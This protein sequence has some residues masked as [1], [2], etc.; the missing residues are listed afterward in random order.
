MSL[1]ILENV[2]LTTFFLNKKKDHALWTARTSSKNSKSKKHVSLNSHRLDKIIMKCLQPFLLSHSASMSILTCLW[3]KFAIV[4]PEAVVAY[5]HLGPVPDVAL[6]LALTS[7]SRRVMV[8]SVVLNAIPLY[9]WADF[10]EIRAVV[11]ITGSLKMAYLTF[12]I[13]CHTKVWQYV[14]LSVLAKTRILYCL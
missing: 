5:L 4:V 13:M 11:N 8:S 9:F 14:S 2:V 10:E 3:N 12:C 1:D 6:F 7:S